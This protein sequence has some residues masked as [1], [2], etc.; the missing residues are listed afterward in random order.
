MHHI[1]PI[2]TKQNGKQKT[3]S[4]FSLEEIK[5]AGITKQQAQQLQIRIDS[6]RKTA[7]EE[8]VETIKAHLP[9]PKS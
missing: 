7:H 2:I 3:G 4:G 1:T 6:R 8:N 5:K 9:K